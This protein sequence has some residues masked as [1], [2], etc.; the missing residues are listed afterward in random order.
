[1]AYSSNYYNY[2]I[3][4]IFAILLGAIILLALIIAAIYYICVVNMRSDKTR[5]RTPSA[6]PLPRRPEY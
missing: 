3:G 2:Q 5:T 6:A 1:M 4:V